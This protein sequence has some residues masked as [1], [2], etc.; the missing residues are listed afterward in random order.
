[1]AE[2]ILSLSENVLAFLGLSHQHSVKLHWVLQIGSAV[3]IAIG[4]AS[5]SVYK[6]QHEDARFDTW[7][8]ITGLI[9]VI[10]FIF[11]CLGGVIALYT[12]TFKKLIK[13]AHVKLAHI[14]VG[15]LTFVIGIISEIFG[16]Y[17]RWF[18]YYC[19]ETVQLVCTL[20]IVL[21][22]VLTLQSS[23]VNAYHRIN[24]LCHN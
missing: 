12:A 11:A 17:T 20:L 14:I 5:I 15:I 8:A 3:A 6:Y 4:F 18:L 16:I 23:L 13:P 21:A 2:S 1:M 9:S 22:T 24:R 10:L 19:N 7:H